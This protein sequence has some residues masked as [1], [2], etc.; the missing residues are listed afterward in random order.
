MRK[1]ALAST[2]FVLLFLFVMSA[3]AGAAALASFMGRFVTDV[4]ST[5]SSIILF[6]GA[7][8]VEYAANGKD[9]VVQIVGKEDVYVNLGR[10]VSLDTITK[11]GS[12]SAKID[13][14]R[15]V[16][17]PG[18]HSGEFL[19]QE[20]GLAQSFSK[21]LKEALSMPEL[22]SRI[23][24]E[25]SGRSSL[26]RNNLSEG[27]I[28]TEVDQQVVVNFEGL[29]EPAIRRICQETG[30]LIKQFLE[31]GNFELASTNRAIINAAEDGAK[32]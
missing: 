23:N 5:N 17:R 26:L 8:R 15:L 27:H 6:R 19:H 32:F 13:V 4:I 12:L 1:K 30:R 28:L 22:E 18:D 29:P 20:T 14:A 2:T 21:T 24:V 3:N 16:R 31:H 10:G 7:N 11:P 25:Y 9:L